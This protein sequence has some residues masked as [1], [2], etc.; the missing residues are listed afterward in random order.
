MGQKVLSEESFAEIVDVAVVDVDDVTTDYSGRG[1]Y[2]MQCLGLT[3]SLAGLAH[4]LVQVTTLYD[5]KVADDNE[6]EWEPDW[7]TQPESDQLGLGMIFYFPTV[8]VE[9]SSADKK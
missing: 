9:K 1:M 7:F 5:E 8:T 4:F 3:V 2:G 6:P